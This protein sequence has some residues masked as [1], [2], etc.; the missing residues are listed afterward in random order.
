[1]ND[2]NNGVTNTNS[3]PMSTYT[4]QPANSGM[5]PSKNASSLWAAIIVCF[6]LALIGIGLGIY[7]ITQANVSPNIIAS[8]IEEAA[9][10]LEEEV[11]VCALPSNANAIEYILLLYNDINDYIEISKDNSIDFYTYIKNANGGGAETSTTINADTSDLIRFFYDND[12]Q[13]FSEGNNPEIA[14]DWVWSVT[15]STNNNECTVGSNQTTPEWLNTLI[16]MANTK[17]DNQ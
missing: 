2:P 1:M 9:S 10:N 6:F 12:L 3:I 5:S 8:D 17:K 15:V 11:V 13:Y 16:N 14:N 4:R 7:G